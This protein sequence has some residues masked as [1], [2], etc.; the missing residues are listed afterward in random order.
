MTARQQRYRS[1][2]SYRRRVIASAT[3]WQRA[4]SR[5]PKYKRLI[6]VRKRIVE[7]RDSY[8]RWSARAEQRFAQ[9]Q[10]LIVERDRLAAE[11]RARKRESAC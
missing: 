11:W 2:E 6:A 7:V 3:A 8:Q 9:L 1:D 4:A 5:D 10:R